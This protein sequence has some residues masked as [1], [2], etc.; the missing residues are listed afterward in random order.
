MVVKSILL[1]T[2]MSRLEKVNTSPK[3]RNIIN[4]TQILHIVTLNPNQ[5]N[6]FTV[7]STPTTGI[8]NNLKL[9]I[10]QGFLFLCRK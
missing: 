3:L 6:T 8:L 7:I 2:L 1:T 5:I 4:F 9:L 10:Y